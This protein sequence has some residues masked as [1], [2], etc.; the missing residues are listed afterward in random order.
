MTF[1][2]AIDIILNLEGGYVNDPHDRGGETKYG[3]TKARY[4]KEDIPNVTLERAKFLY[5]LD[6]WEK[7]QIKAYPDYM[8]LLIFDMY[9]NHSPKGAAKIIQ[10][11]INHK[12]GKQAL[13]IDGIAGH[14]TRTAATL[15]KPEVARILSFRAKYYVNIV[16]RNPTQL[17]FFYGWMN[18]RVFHLLNIA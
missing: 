9:V 13:K 14:W 5:K 1:E 15:F 16:D 7:Y 18:Q 11:A 17:R 6:F 3:I 2:Q 8:R 12:A 10:R 4:P